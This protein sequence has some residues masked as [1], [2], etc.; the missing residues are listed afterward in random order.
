[1]TGKKLTILVQITQ[2]ESVVSFHVKI[3]NSAAVVLFMPT[4]YITTFNDNACNIILHV[5]KN[6]DSFNG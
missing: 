3:L 4:I 2:I 1:M 6:W 5:I